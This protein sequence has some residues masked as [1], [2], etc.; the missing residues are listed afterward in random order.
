MRRSVFLFA[1]LMFGCGGGDAQTPVEPLPGDEDTSNNT[2]ETATGEDSGDPG[3]DVGGGDDTGGSGG[4]ATVTDTA[5][6]TNTDVLV[7]DAPG[8]T[9]CAT[10]EVLAAKPPV[11][12]IVVVDQSGSMNDDIVRVKA[13]INKLS[14][15][16]KATGL[17]YRVV[18][19]ARVGT[20]TAATSTDICVPPPLGGP[21]TDC[22]AT[23]KPLRNSNPPIYRTSNQ[24]IGSVDA[25]SK[26]LSTYDNPTV[27]IGWKDAIRPEAYK[28]IVP[29][30]DD[31]SS[32]NEV[33]F[34]TQLLAKGAGVF[35]T[36]TARKYGAFPIMGSST[37]PSE[38]RCGTTM[39]NNGPTYVKLVKLVGGKWFP[40]CS[41][42]FGPLFTDM[43]KT[44]AG[45]VA[46][47]V[48]VPPPPAGEVFDPGKINVV[49]TPSSGGSVP[50]ARDDKPCASGSNGWQLS[51]DGTK[52]L[53]CG[54]ACTGLKA[55]PGGKVSVQFGCAGKA[56]PPPPDAG[57]CTPFGAKCGDADIC[58]APLA[59]LPGPDGSNICRAKGPA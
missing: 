33:S 46:C 44:I 47:E 3:F 55:D 41:T 25:L 31:N 18:M 15:Y 56:P 7:F 29:I 1:A 42:D 22:G 59:C 8:D 32:L 23:T 40:L 38:V 14:D 30:T 51:P 2:G 43:A 35:G 48:A 4:D 20:S 36:A 45:V 26:L 9:T 54:T 39:V 28:A 50:I 19:I 12:V 57:T 49:Y 17:D 6:D 10:S 52:I 37:Y 27:G 11:D 34:D 24:T 53:L 5:F 16:L 21:L 13:N 58:C